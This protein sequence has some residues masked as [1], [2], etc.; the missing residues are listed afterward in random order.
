MFER[1]IK[2]I[3]R[4]V[5][6]K[7]GLLYYDGANLNAVMGKIRPGD[8]G[9]DIMHINLH[10]TFSTPHG[11]G[12]P[13]SGPI[14]CKRGL[15]PFLPYPSVIRNEE[16][17][18][19]LKK[20]SELSIGKARAFYGNF[21]VCVKAFAYITAL[22]KEGIRDAAEKAVLNAN[23]MKALVSEFLKVPYGSLCMHEFV[24]SCEDLKE[25]TGI[26]A[27]DVAKSLIDKG[28]HPPTIYFPLI[29]HEALMFEPT[30]TE[31]KE[32]IDCAVE[33]LRQSVAAAAMNPES[34]K[35]APST[36]PIGRPDEVKA[37]RKPI[38]KF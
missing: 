29:V 31:S 1:N 14:L 24:A 38:L 4:I 3:A 10:K 20:L 12:G 15:I 17:K 18:F 6:S 13:G 7:G 35:N 25:K 2:Q 36:T 37:A 9:F 26:S 16:G 22:G 27:L 8:M 19:S 32:S 33:K 28:M 5:H 34:L 23:Y 30:E 21:L 11:G